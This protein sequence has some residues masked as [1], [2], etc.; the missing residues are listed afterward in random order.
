ME[1]AVKTIHEQKQKLAGGFLNNAGIL[2]GV[3]ICLV[4]ILL[5]TNEV[6]VNS[7]EEI[8]SLGANFFLLLFCSYFMY[9]SCSDSG[10]RAGK[11]S[12]AYDEAT[13]RH[14]RLKRTLVESNMLGRLLEFCVHYVQEE[15]KSARVSV[16]AFAGVSYADYEGKW[17]AADT[18]SVKESTELT[19]IQKSA[20]IKAN[21][22]HPIRLTPD[23]FMPRGSGKS[24]RS[25]IGKT[26]NAKKSF[27]FAL[28]LLIT[29]GTVALTLIEFNPSEQSIWVFLASCSTN[30]AVVVINGFSG[31]K[32][33]YE[34]IVS[35]TV[36][37][38]SDQSDMIERAIQYVEAN[39]YEENRDKC[40][41]EGRN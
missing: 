13:K 32:F 22:I 7:F 1:T 23:M 10:M 17:L 31:Y 9:I 40:I 6:T 4:V 34:N 26:P 18:K 35:D 28:K 3:F 41:N 39:P 27:G 2:I 8:L 11:R 14:E 25:P 37:Y 38:I 21:K 20:I 30:L 12:R 5:S 16:L 29:V 19:E 33:G 24:G 36:S 15:L